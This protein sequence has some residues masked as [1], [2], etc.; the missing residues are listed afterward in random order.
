MVFGR[1]TMKTGQMVIRY[2]IDVV[3]AGIIFYLANMVVTAVGSLGIIISTLFTIVVAAYYV[4][5]IQK[6]RPGRETFLD[7]IIGI[8]IGTSVLALMTALF[9]IALPAI[10]IVG[11][12]SL[13]GFLLAITS[14]WLADTIVLKVMKRR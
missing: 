7:L 13:F 8:V 6:L 3:L 10:T 11:G 12:I 4:P 1:K 5:F 14:F 2:T 9:G